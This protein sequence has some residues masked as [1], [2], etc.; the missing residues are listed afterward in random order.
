MNITVSTS[1]YTSWRKEGEDFTYTR[2]EKTYSSFRTSL[3]ICTL[4]YKYHLYIAS[5]VQLDFTN[6]ADVEWAEGGRGGAGQEERVPEPQVS[7]FKSI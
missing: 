1:A 6:S 4:F 5:A 3:N 2:S 7:P